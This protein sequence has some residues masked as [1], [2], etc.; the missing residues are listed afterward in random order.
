MALEVRWTK[1]AFADLNSAFEFISS[2]SQ[3]SA[4]KV[5]K[6]IL[7]SLKQ[8]KSFPESGKDGRVNGTREFFVSTTPYF[9][10]YKFKANHLEILNV[11]HSSRKWP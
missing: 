7:D 5:V 2:E 1:I 10:V 3:P 8:L 4:R 11:L 6:K 9:I